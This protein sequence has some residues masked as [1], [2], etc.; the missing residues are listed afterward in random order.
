MALRLR[1]LAA[2]ALLV[3]LPPAVPGFF[4]SGATPTSAQ[5]HASAPDRH[6]SAARRPRERRRDPP[7]RLAGRASHQFEDGPGLAWHRPCNTPRLPDTG[8]A[9]SGRSPAAGPGSSRSRPTAV[10][11]GSRRTTRTR[12]PPPGAEMRPWAS[13]WRRMGT[14]WRVSNAPSRS[15]CWRRGRWRRSPAPSPIRPSRS[16]PPTS[17]S[18]TQDEA[19]ALL[20]DLAAGADFATL[21]E[22]VFAGRQHTAS[23]RRS[24]LVPARVP[25]GAGSRRRRLGAC[26][27]RDER[28]HR[29]FPGL[30]Y[31]P[32]V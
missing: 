11:R 28:R 15:M 4:L 25:V 21:A 10:R 6:T 13:G 1:S 24:G 8:A 23:R 19:A 26:S 22:T 14:P 30:S 31:C 3:G 32:R 16:T 29:E 17:S 20:A 12:W 27:R 7:G 2:F 9:G 5:R 18:R